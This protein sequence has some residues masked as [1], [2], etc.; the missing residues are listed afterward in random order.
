MKIYKLFIIFLFVLISLVPLI[1][2]NTKD[3]QISKIDN[4]KLP[5][6]DSIDSVFSFNNYVSKRIGFRESIIYFYTVSNDKLFKAMVHPTYT[7]GKDGWVFFK[8]SI[9]KRD[10]EWLDNFAKFV[11][12]MQ[13]YVREKGS[14][15]LFVINPTKVSVYSEYLKSGYNFENY[16]INYLKNKLNELNIN[17]IDNTDFLKECSKTQ[18]VFNKKYDAGHW[19]DTGAFLGFTN[20]YNKLISDGIKIDNLNLDDYIIKEKLQTTL[21]VSEFPINE[22]VPEYSLKKLNYKVSN[23]YNSTVKLNNNFKFYLETENENKKLPSLLFFR[24]S[25]VNDKEKFL[26]NQFGNMYLVHNYQN[27][28]NYEYYYNLFEKPEVVMLEIVEYATNSS[29]YTL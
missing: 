12:N 2:I 26:G 10:N 17:Y 24:G 16:R 18:K 9:E 1:L 25:Y 3:N 23:K 5:E 20:I 27:S 13:N 21:P 19:N 8:D 15:F 28:L 14:Y 11:S 6:I 22:Y 7:Y 29:Y 4:T